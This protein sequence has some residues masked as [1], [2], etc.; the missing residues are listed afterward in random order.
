MNTNWFVINF[1]LYSKNV[2]EF[3]CILYYILGL[4]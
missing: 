1:L 2:I 4:I 3:A